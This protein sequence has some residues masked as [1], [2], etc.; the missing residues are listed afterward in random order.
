MTVNNNYELESYTANGT[1]TDFDFTFKIL[2]KENIIVNV[3]DTNGVVTKKA[4]TTDYTISLNDDN[5]GTVIFNTAP[6]NNYEVYIERLV[7]IDQEVNLETSSGFQESVIENSLDKLTMI[8]QQHQADLD[9]C[10][11]VSQ[12]NDVIIS[13]GEVPVDT[14]C[15]VWSENLDGSFN[16][17][18]SE[19]NPDTVYND[20][21][22]NANVIAVADNITSINT[23]ATNIANV[24]T[25]ATN[26][27]NINIVAP[28][29]DNVNIVANNIDDINSIL[30]SART[31]GEIVQSTIPLTSAELH[32]LDG[33]LIL[34]GGSYN[35]FYL[36]MKGLYDGGLYPNIF[37]TEVNW[38][39]SVST[40]GVCGK[41]VF[42][43][44]VSV[45]LPK[46]T[47]FVEGTITPT[48]LGNLTEAGLPNITGTISTSGA[49][50]GSTGCVTYST[51][52][53]ALE[54]GNAGGNLQVF[55]IN[56]SL[57]SSI[58]GSSTTVQPQSIKV[59]YYICV[60]TS[61][62]TDIVVDIDNIITDLNSK[63]D[64][65]LSNV[66]STDI[67]ANAYIA[68]K[69]TNISG[70]GYTRMI[71]GTSGSNLSLPAGG[72]WVVL[73]SYAVNETNA[74]ISNTAADDLIGT[75]NRVLAGGTLIR[76]A[77]SGLI[78]QAIVMRI[79]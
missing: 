7:D 49:N 56:A 70:V 74:A 57:S 16:I 54:A 75:G 2:E 67:Y 69:P 47:G 71:Q 26:I 72:T 23:V 62:K 76:S 27:N 33:G 15:L 61:V 68:P 5:T 39:A 30:K 14:K 41:F 44:G 8:T 38:Q 37:E 28:D 51:P 53:T 24:N 79:L 13:S 19:N 29:I 21:V 34:A 46:I 3:K 77:R 11:K 43:D 20:I 78:P 65:N 66:T 42:I 6:L 17:V 32:L 1:I 64:K 52:S 18:N 59:L 40:Y 50:S 36:H 12:F 22:N 9:K 4:L 45:R 48:N 10:L 35:A 63:A 31:V 58:Y 60:A 55:T 73:A 25:N